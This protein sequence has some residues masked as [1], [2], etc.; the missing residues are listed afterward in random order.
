MIRC[1]SEAHQLSGHEDD[2]ADVDEVAAHFERAREDA[3]LETRRVADALSHEMFGKP[4][5]L[6]L[7]GRYEVLELVGA[8]GIGVVYTARDPQLDRIVALKLIQS[9]HS[10]GDYDLARLEREAQA[11]ARLSHPNV[12][13]VFEVGRHEGSPFIAMEYIEGTT[14][15]RWLKTERDADEV[16]SMFLAAGRGV[17]AAHRAGLVHRDFKPSNVLVGSDGRARVL[18]F[19]LAR[20]PGAVGGPA[21]GDVASPSGPSSSLTQPGSFVGTPAYS[22]PEQL[23]GDSVDARADV[24]S[25]CVA[26]WEGLFGQRPNA[27]SK[28]G[29]TAAPPRSAAWLVGIL[30][31]GL[32]ENPDERPRDLG[33]LVARVEKA[34]GRR[35][36]W[37]WGL[38]AAALASGVAVLSWSAG[39]EA[40]GC[41][42]PV[43][44]KELA[45]VWDASV[46]ESLREAFGEQLA[47]FAPDTWQS[48]EPILDAYASEW[49]D[50]RESSCLDLQA[51]ATPQRLETQACLTGRLRELATLTRVYA[52]P[53][54]E[55][56][57]RVVE[58]AA[59][60]PDIEDCGGAGEA[61]AKPTESVDLAL[62]E[63]RALRRTGR[64]A[65][66]LEVAKS[67]ADEA[68]RAGD[69]V[70]E[71]HAAALIG[72]LAAARGDFAG[73]EEQLL[74]A[75]EK[76]E[77]RQ[78]DSLTLDVALGL[79]RILSYTPARS[80]EAERWAQ[81][82]RGK[83]AAKAP[84]RE[85]ELLNLEANIA[86]GSGR[87]EQ[88]LT[89]YARL[90]EAPSD[91]S[92]G[93]E[94][95]RAEISSNLG[96]TQTALGR[97]EEAR[98]SLEWA[99]EV[100]ESRLGTDHPAVARGHGF[101][102]NLYS[103]QGLARLTLEHAEQAHRRY[104][105][106][107]D[108][109]DVE[110]TAAHLNYAAALEAV[111]RP[112][113]ALA[114]ALEV[115]A[116]ARDRPEYPLLGLAH[117]NAADV[118]VQLDRLDE[119]LEHATQGVD[120]LE[121]ALGK[122]HPQLV[123][124]SLILGKVHTARGEH[125]LARPSIE[126][127]REQL[128]GTMGPLHSD[129]LAATRALAE[130]ELAMGNADRAAELMTGALDALADANEP[131]ERERCRFARARALAA[132]PARADEALAQAR[133][134]LSSMPDPKSRDALEIVAWLDAHDR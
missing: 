52:T 35:R 2:G 63:A 61:E 49:L 28:S 83:I 69:E 36:R 50:A 125:E 96:I 73:A 128:A 30:Q 79:V 112:E 81:L 47:P 75:L 9:A 58:A 94:L 6:G 68:R 23:R 98:G 19:G 86:F 127:A 76:A 29:S 51:E 110:R 108:E 111:A 131:F 8:G 5:E 78:L 100:F 11:L 74:A 66:A 37:G 31:E 22:A 25:F 119:A 130:L 4:R 27:R 134:A 33:E 45:G 132:D 129:T 18:D 55:L 12:V 39:S 113:D 120:A 87:Y 106:L 121:Q 40:S 65:D 89:S 64:T 14:L 107:V 105:A 26:L 20:E 116:A 41:S 82:A 91:G 99:L 21:P 7:I 32:A 42:R 114:G 101:L 97:Y 84:E 77:A 53:D 10:D 71:A 104:V 44:E 115:V 95:H 59:E 16:L 88:A 1:D 13:N 90:L 133:E 126:A 123:A 109:G 3:D 48:V 15:D 93:D 62:A 117:I 54:V 34:R 122:G 118:L 124:A 17:A 38:A 56:A 60:L 102:A 70:G 57:E 85:G 80:E 24:Y 46:R 43:L 92:A 103:R 67:A 72:G